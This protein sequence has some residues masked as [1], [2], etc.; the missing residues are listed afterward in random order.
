MGI[1][2]VNLVDFETWS[3]AGILPAT[4]IREQD[5]PTTLENYGSQTQNRCGL[6]YF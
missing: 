3:S 1:H 2:N 5:A 6:D 4:T